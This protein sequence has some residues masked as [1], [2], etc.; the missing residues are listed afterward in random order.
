MTL[1]NVLLPMRAPYSSLVAQ[2]L[3]YPRNFTSR[4]H[5]FTTLEVF[6]WKTHVCLGLND[7]LAVY[8]FIRMWWDLL[9]I[10]DINVKHLLIWNLRL[11][12][13]KGVFRSSLWT[14]CRIPFSAILRTTQ[15]QNAFTGLRIDI[16]FVHDHEAVFMGQDRL[17]C[18]NCSYLGDT[19][20][21]VYFHHVY[22]IIIY[23]PSWV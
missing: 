23:M 5:T 9:V 22:T 1:Q 16:V 19:G 17:F 4:T 11:K 18:C 21:T 3:T 2:I 14:Y 20:T 6:F 13:R 7:N 12:A 10:R 15:P 8:L